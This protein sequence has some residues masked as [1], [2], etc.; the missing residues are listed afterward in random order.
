MTESNVPKVFI[1]YSWESKEHSDWVKSLADK[2]LSDG[3]EAIIDSYD[4]SPGDRLPKFMESSIRDSDYVIIICTEEYKRKAN[5]R[6]KGVGY[7]SHII[8]AEL[9]NNHNDR[10][11]IPIIRQGDFN[12][13][14][15][16]YLDGKLAIDLRGNPF[17]EES[18]KDLIASIFK[19]KKKPKV[20]IRPYYVDEYEPITIEGEDIKIV[21]II[22]NEV[23]LPKNDGTRGS[24]L[25][26]VPFRLSSKPTDTWSELFLRNWDCPPRFTSIHRPGIAR[27]ESDKIILDGTTIEEVKQY[28]RDTLILCVEKTNEEE[29]QIR[30]REEQLKRKK[31]EEIENHYRNIN[32]ISKDIRF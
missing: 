26:S 28:H 6:E 15:P 27:V 32:D 7:E 30:R 19:V 21:G 1:S 3:I 23:T 2:L 10:K 31:Q 4:V 5:N 25:Y 16:T 8:S 12:T 24:A 13:A 14:L 17:N 29:K 20:G 18:Y 11:F 9:Y 22:T